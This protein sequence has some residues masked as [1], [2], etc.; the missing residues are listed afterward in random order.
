MTNISGKKSFMGFTL[1]E[2]ITVVIVLSVLAGLAVPRYFTTIEKVRSS[3]GVHTLTVLLSAQKRYF[4]ENNAYKAGTG[5][6]GA[7]TCGG[8]TRLKNSPSGD[9]DVDI[10][11]SNNFDIPCINNGEPIASVVR[12]NGATKLYTLDITSAGVINCTNSAPYT[13]CSKIKSW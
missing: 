7:V 8:G 13:Y 10:P 3:E 11:T 1:L 2:L 4:L 9:L 5:A 12:N 6:G